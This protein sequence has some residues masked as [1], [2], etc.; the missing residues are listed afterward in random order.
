MRDEASLGA[1]L[2]LPATIVLRDGRRVTVREIL[3]DDR[4]ALQAAVANTS[5]DSRYARFMTSLR[6]IPDKM[7]DAATHPVPDKEFALVALED[8]VAR[9]VGGA[10]YAAEAVADRCEFAIMV[11]D[12][13][14]HMGLAPCLMEMLIA[15]AR[16]HGFLFIEGFVLSTN[17]P[18]RRLAKRFGFQE[19]PCPDDATVRVVRRALDGGHEVASR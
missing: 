13:W 8:D 17:A 4:D 5:A 2:S 10:R 16:A 11:V 19:S 1:G 15:A 18:M 9:I 12:D 14:R 7:L 3:P 6:E